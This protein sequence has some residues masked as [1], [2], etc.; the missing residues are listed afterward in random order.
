L[1]NLGDLWGNDVIPTVI[2]A[3]DY[4]IGAD[5]LASHGL[6]DMLFMS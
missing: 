2:F 1:P 5:K 6:M 3:S 4:C